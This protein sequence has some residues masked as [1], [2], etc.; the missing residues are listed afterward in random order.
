MYNVKLNTFGYSEPDFLADLKVSY[1]E[2]AYEKLQEVA[3]N[4]DRKDRLKVKMMIDH[5]ILTRTNAELIQ[6]TIDGL[7][8]VEVNATAYD[9]YDKRNIDL[10]A[11]A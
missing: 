2:T 9:G 7:L 10:P 1:P 8:A 5:K 11:E 6:L 3:H 4:H